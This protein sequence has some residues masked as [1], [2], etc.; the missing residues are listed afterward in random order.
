[1]FV[2]AEAIKHE[3]Q[4]LIDGIHAR[5]INQQD[6]EVASYIPQL[7]KSNPK[8]FGIAILSA[9][10]QLFE[11]GNTDT[12]FTIQSISKPLTYGMALE[13]YGPE[14]IEKK[15]DVEPSGD[16][17]NAIELEPKTNR[18][19]NPMVNAGA[20][21]ASAMLFDKYG[22]DAIEFILE[23]FSLAAGRPLEIDKEVYWSESKTGHRNR[24]IAYLLLNFNMISDY[25]EPILE[26]YFAQCSILINC[27]DL[28]SIAATIANVGENPVTKKEV[29]SIDAVKSMMSVMYICGMYDNTGR[30]VNEVGIPAKS[31]VSGG[32][33]GVV[34]RQMGI[35]TYSPMLD[36][37]G[38]SCRG[39]SAYKELSR[40]LG[41]HTFD[42]MNS[43]SSFL[44][45]MLK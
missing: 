21:T 29:F 40:E 24:A 31:G 12:L 13:I 36:E 20:I 6:G 7:S 26:I 4:S 37:R 33:M 25:V 9:K 28:A 17:F 3:I 14:E 1:M 30:W 11:C 27:R 15:I 22:K 34:N 18:P 45:T 38:N 8:H 35:A 16:A 41:L 2:M 5:Y 39:I 42:C 44:T 23:K 19:Y 43:G 10:G 32:L